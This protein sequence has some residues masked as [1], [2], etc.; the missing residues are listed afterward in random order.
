MRSVHSAISFRYHPT[1]PDLQSARAIAIED[2]T[3]DPRQEDVA[4]LGS[5]L[6][7]LF[8]QQEPDPGQRVAHIDMIENRQATPRNSSVYMET[9]GICAV[10]ASGIYIR[11]QWTFNLSQ[12]F[13]AGRPDLCWGGTATNSCNARRC[14]C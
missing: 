4:A 3:L 14:R 7:A 9:V 10:F 5:L 13:R 6:G 8:T 1:V 12:C 11:S 2:V